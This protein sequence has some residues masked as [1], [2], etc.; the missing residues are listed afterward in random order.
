MDESSNFY[1]IRFHGIVHKRW[2]SQFGAMQMIYL[3]DGD[4]ML[5]G[6][7]QD[8]SQLV[9]IINHIH[10]LNLKL[11]SVICEINLEEES[12]EVEGKT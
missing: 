3:E 6:Q 7:V 8:Q 1:Q 11:I 2:Q 4:V 5:R 10:N 9:G 12:T